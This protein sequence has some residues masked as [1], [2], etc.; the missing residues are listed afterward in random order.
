MIAIATS[1]TE[2]VRIEDLCSVATAAEIAGFHRSWIHGLVQRGK[3][4]CVEID[5]IHFVRRSDAAS[6]Q[7]G[8]PGRPKKVS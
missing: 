7:R 3:L 6:L 8:K 4:W 5:G 1:K 2:T